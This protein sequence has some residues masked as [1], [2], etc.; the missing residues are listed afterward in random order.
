MVTEGLRPGQKM[1]GCVV[2]QITQIPELRSEAVLFTHETTGARILHL[3]NEDKNNLF[4]IGFRTPVYNNT[5]VPHIIEHS[6]LSGSRKFPLKD[7]FKEMLKGSLQTFLNAIT[8]PD[9]T[10]YPVSSQVERDFY[11]LVDVYCDAVFNPLLSETTFAQEGWHFDLEKPDIPISIKGIVYNEMKGVYSDFRSHV[12]RKTL[13]ALFPDTTYFFESGGEPEHIP[14]LTYEQFKR[15]HEQYYH[16]SNA[17]V[18]LYGTIPSEKS[19]AF[20]HTNYLSRFSYRAVDSHIPLQ[21]PWDM[22]RRIHITAPSSKEDDGTASVIVSWLTGAVT[23]PMQVLL[24][25][26]LSHYFFDNEGSPLRRALIDSGLGEDLDDMCGYDPDLVQGLFCAGLRKTKPGHANAIVKIIFDTLQTEVQKGLDA[27]LLEGSIRQIEFR[28]RE[29]SDGGHFPYNLMLAERVYRSWI[30]G[31]NPLAHLQFDAPLQLI[32]NHKSAGVDFFV[33]ALHAML[34][35]NTHY[36]VSVVEASSDMGE[37]LGK[38]TERQAAAL[39]EHFT[40]ADRKQWHELTQRILEDQKKPPSAEALATLPK[41]HRADLPKENEKV[42]VFLKNLGEVPVYTHPLFTSGIVYV[43]IGFD[44]ATLP[45]DLL[46]Y[47]PFYSELLTRCG[48]GGF[49]YQ[50]MAKRISLCTGGIST[51]DICS[52]KFQ[53]S[54]DVALYCFFHGKALHERVDDMLGVFVDYFKTPELDNEKLITDILLETR[55]ELQGSVIR[56]GNYFAITNSGSRLSKSK[57]IDE[58]FDG[59]FQL[60]FLDTLIKKNALADVIAAMKRLHNIIINRKAC[61]LSITCDDP[62]KYMP[63][64][65]ALVDSLP[66]RQCA[67]VT[68]DFKPQHET[69]PLA[70]EISS[71][72]NF[73]ARSWDLEALT[74]ESMGEYFLLSRNLSTGYLWDS[75]RVEGGAYGGM[76]IIS[77]AHPVFSCASYRDPNCAKTLDNF[78]KGLIHA[79]KKLTEDDV[80]QSVVG[81]IGKLDHP[82][83]P[84]A[85]GFGETAALLCGH[86]EELRQH[87]RDAI[88]GCSVKVLAKRAKRLLNQKKNA[89]T[90]FGSADAFTQ[91]EKEGLT[92]HRERLL[93]E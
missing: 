16:P 86:T 9:K 63:S 74:P 11:N 51:S 84:H 7:P 48:A 66:V 4:C 32:K 8:Y 68:I 33:Q 92:L 39:T 35:H 87:I 21:K 75:V 71:S 29:I 55:N 67:P 17:F 22:P 6:V 27:D 83:S 47:F 81:A 72:V 62:S 34:I 77:S 38:K 88:L 5:G 70:I 73:V 30:Y 24:G 52:T 15:F 79:M 60:R 41:L 46:P 18:V 2:E 65:K 93:Q 3:F 54:D 45:V 10:I 37:E 56:S 69:L 64:L 14:E 26:I 89:I 76:A 31:G 1:H 49:S 43:D 50:E 57:Y 13:S 42:P 23:D 25:K 61:A 40:E 20:L 28:L 78:E 36:L 90:V 44:M 58:L 53:T 19:L 59:V 91:A 82:R 80:D 85:K 12:A